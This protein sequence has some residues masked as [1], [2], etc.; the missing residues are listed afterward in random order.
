[1]AIHSAGKVECWEDRYAEMELYCFSL[2]RLRGSRRPRLS[3][4]QGPRCSLLPAEAAAAAELG[5]SGISRLFPTVF[6]E[7]EPSPLWTPDLAAAAAR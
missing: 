6:Q 7:R 4:E 3:V 1:M 5:P 2:V